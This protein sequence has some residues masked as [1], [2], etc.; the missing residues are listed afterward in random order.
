M[1]NGQRFDPRAM[2][3]AHRTL[4]LGTWV[5]VTRT[6][7]G[8]T[9]RVR[10]TDRGPFGDPS[11]IIDLS[12][13]AAERLDMVRLGVAPVEVRVVEGPSPSPSNFQVKAP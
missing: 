9:V 1:A 5:D 3:A 11:R 12:K 2:T 10:I 13:A 4:P 7:R 8:R 6:D